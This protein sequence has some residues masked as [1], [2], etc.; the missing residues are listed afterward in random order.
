[1]SRR[2][3]AAGRPCAILGAFAKQP[4][5]KAM[6]GPARHWPKRLAAAYLRMMGATQ[7]EAGASVGRH[8]DTVRRWE[9]EATWPQAREEARCLWMDDAADVARRAVL[10]AVRAGNSDLGFKIL[11]R[12]DPRFAP[13]KHRPSGR[14]DVNVTGGTLV[15]RGMMTPEDWNDA[16]RRLHD[17]PLTGGEGN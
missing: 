14:E 9:R 5:L 4:A 3:R 17:R 12:T 16:A 11:E 6:K 15:V 8:E 2:S 7:A 13:K 10:A 1:M